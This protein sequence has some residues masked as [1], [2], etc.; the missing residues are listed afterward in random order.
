MNLYGIDVVVSDDGIHHVIDCNY[1]S[2]YNGIPESEISQ[3]FDDFITE[4]MSH[5]NTEVS[6][7]TSYNKVA[8][9]SIGLLA[10]AFVGL[11]IWKK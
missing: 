7:L 3:A 11:K 5:N 1:F 8:A 9:L 4:K 6:K 2:S 10:A